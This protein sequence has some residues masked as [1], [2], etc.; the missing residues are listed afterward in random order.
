M[1]IAPTVRKLRNF[2]VIQDGGFCEKANATVL[3]DAYPSVNL[4]ENQL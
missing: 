2:F 4:S 1:K 3:S